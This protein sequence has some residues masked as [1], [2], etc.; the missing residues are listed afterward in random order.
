M[1]GSPAIQLYFGDWIKDK[2]LSFCSW[3]ARG[4]WI[5]VMGLMHNG[6]EYGVLRQPLSKI[7]QAVGAPPKLLRELVEQGAMRGCDKGMHAAVVWAPKHAR[8][9]GAEV[10]LLPEQQGPI[11][12]SFRMV[13]DAYVRSRRGESSRF[14]DAPKTPIGDESG[15]PPMPPPNALEGD[16]P[17]SSSSSSS[18]N[19]HYESLGSEVSANTDAR[20]RVEAC[21]LLRKIGMLDVQPQRPELFDLVGRGTTLEQMAMTA[22]ELALRKANFLNDSDM[23]PDLLVLLASGATQQQMNLTNEQYAHLRASVPKLPYLAATLNGRLAD[24]KTRASTPQPS[25]KQSV[26]ASFKDQTYAG[27]SLD[28]LPESLRARVEGQLAD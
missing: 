3:G 27:T 8:T 5:H 7:A 26:T 25:S 14:G 22:A 4:V 28:Q 21:K 15:A 10:V 16:G 13:K 17:S 19:Q 9:T 20:T 18:S 1:A 12:Y 2:Q 23:H 11:W 6:E 24:A